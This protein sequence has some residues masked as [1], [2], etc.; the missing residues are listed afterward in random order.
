MQAALHRAQ[1]PCI[2][3]L[4]ECVCRSQQKAAGRASSPARQPAP[5]AERPHASA[6]VP[7][8][9]PGLPQPVL[10]RPSVPDGFRPAE[11]SAESSVPS[12]RADVQ[13]AFPDTQQLQSNL[14]R[15]AT[16]PLARLQAAAEGQAGMHGGHSCRPSVLRHSPH[17]CSVYTAA[18]APPYVTVICSCS[19]AWSFTSVVN[20]VWQGSAKCTMDCSVGTDCGWCALQV[21]KLLG[22]KVR[23]II[24]LPLLS[25]P[26]GAALLSSLAQLRWATAC[27]M[28]SQRTFAPGTR[29]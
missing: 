15:P 27:L 9:L 13:S 3:R 14:M 5:L 8:T 10:Q 16:P 29:S 22:V 6:P 17:A 12:G 1:Q 19:A 2:M 4:C 25:L 20:E 18:S 7:P 23:L 24:R 28:A 11:P 26:F 21:C